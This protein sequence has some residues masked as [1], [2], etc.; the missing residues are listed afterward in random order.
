MREILTILLLSFTTTLSAATQEPKQDNQPRS[1]ENTLRELTQQWDQA[2]VTQDM[3]VLDR[4]LSDDY[5]I[6]G[7]SKSNY[8]QLMKE[9]KYVSAHRSGITVRIYGDTALLIGRNEL[10][11]QTGDS[12]FSGSFGFMDVWVK[13][14]SVWRCVATM[15]NDIRQTSQDERDKMVRVG[16]DVKA[17]LVIYFK[18]GVTGEQIEAFSLR[19]LHGAIDERRGT[20][21]R[22][23]ICEFLRLFPLQSH[24]AIAIQFCE[25]AGEEQRRTIKAAILS[26]SVVYK[27]LENV[28]P[29]DVKR[30]D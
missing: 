27:V 5:T 12:G 23:G 14:Q 6:S 21:L 1:V 11:G 4:M 24:D 7:M 26:S 16:P 9:V 3:A 20:P 18:V 19:Y 17:S 13:Q 25:S 8:L 10:T 30:I 28:A 22:E 2:I 29:A 15:A